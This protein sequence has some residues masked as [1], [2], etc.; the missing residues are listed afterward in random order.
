MTEQP[1]RD[2][3]R[4]AASFALLPMVR[5]EAELVLSNGNVVT[6]DDAQPRARAVAIAGGRFLAVGSDADV[7]NLAT[8]RRRRSTWAAAPW[9]R[10]S[11]TGTPTSPPR[12]TCT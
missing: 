4:N 9:C 8:A 1:R 12:A 7:L 5:T 11:S 3:L 6:V 10:A 2:F